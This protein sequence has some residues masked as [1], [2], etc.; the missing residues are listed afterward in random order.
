MGC[1]YL[2]GENDLGKQSFFVNRYR[3]KSKEFYL[4]GDS[5][6]LEPENSAKPQIKKMF[7]ICN[8]YLKMTRSS[9]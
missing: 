1:S 5:E 6:F 7:C 3:N 2:W 9:Y 4:T 8:S